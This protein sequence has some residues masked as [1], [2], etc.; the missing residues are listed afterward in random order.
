M[1]QNESKMKNRQAFPLCTAF[2]DWV[3]SEVGADQVKYIKAT[4]NG[5]SIEWGERQTPDDE[6]VVVS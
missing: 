6:G 2:I 5:F 3:R 4:E 1:S